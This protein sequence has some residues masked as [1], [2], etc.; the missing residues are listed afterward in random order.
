ME[1]YLIALDMDGTLLQSDQTISKHTKQYLNDLSKKGHIVVIASGRPFR[2]ITNHYDYLELDTPVICYNGA[3]IH[4]GK[5]QFT[6]ESF[7]FPNKVIKE[8]INQIGYDKLINV[9]CETNKEIWLLKEDEILKKFF[10]HDGMNIIYGDLQKT[11]NS[12]PMTML[13]QTKDTKYNQEIAKAIESHKGLKCRFW[14]GTWEDISEIYFE[15]INKGSA[16]EIIKDFYQ[17]D[18]AHTIAIGDAT[19]DID[20]FN[21]AGIKI[22]M[23]NSIAELKE[24]ATHITPED[25]DH[26]GVVSG[27]KLIIKGD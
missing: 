11:L 14:S 4:Q 18:T 10:I 16:L 22:A 8:I 26:N 17:I 13:I 5:S 20:L 15:Q 9:M 21:S 7:A 27:L 1:K 2:S 25:N 24:T 6:E 3:N 23:K 19:N 12:D